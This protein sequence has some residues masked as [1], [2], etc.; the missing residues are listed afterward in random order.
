MRTTTASTTL[1][2]LVAACCLLGLVQSTWI[3]HGHEDVEV[4]PSV[5]VNLIDPARLHF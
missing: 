5:L 1:L 3:L 4:S 2:L